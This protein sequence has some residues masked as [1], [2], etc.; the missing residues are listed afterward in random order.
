MNFN[1]SQRGA[2]DLIVAALFIVAFAGIGV[3]LLTKTNAAK[4]SSGVARVQVKKAATQ[5]FLGDGS[6]K[7]LVD[8]SISYLGDIGESTKVV[9]IKAGD[10]LV[11]PGRGVSLQGLPEVL[12]EQYCY[13]L[14]STDG[15]ATVELV[16][17]ES[18]TK[19]VVLKGAPA[20]NESQGSNFWNYECVKQ[21]RKAQAKLP[22]HIKHLGGSDVRVYS[23]EV[24]GTQ[25]F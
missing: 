24:I 19:Q 4:P 9:E 22:Y 12:S 25:S 16:G 14:R 13:I 3:Y 23:L 2:I 1:K 15:E 17:P 11:F 18:A 10:E 5:A 7:N 6:D 8:D 21:P 20:P